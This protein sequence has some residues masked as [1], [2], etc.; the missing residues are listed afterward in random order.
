MATRNNFQTN[1][2]TMEWIDRYLLE[3]L[4]QDELR[5]FH[6]QMEEDID[7][8]TLVMNQKQE[9]E[10]VEEYNLRQSMETYHKEISEEGRFKKFSPKSW[11]IAASILLLASFSLWT[12]YNKDTSSDA[13]KIF[14]DNFKPDPGL[15]TTMGKTTDYEFYLG[16]VSYKQKKYAEAISQWEPLYAAAPQND[17]ITYFLG[18]A[19]LAIGDTH[20]AEKYLE[21]SSGKKDVAFKEESDYYLALTYLK[22]NKIKEA[23][24]LLKLS[25]YPVNIKLLEQIEKLE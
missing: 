18:V 24:E 4:D 14:S 13:Q 1:Q 5:Q 23:K 10:V 2:E 21:I 11:A 9:M 17:T 6:K 12:I 20:Q 19:H 8:R 25:S 15:P 16:M 3:Q 7:F 22:E